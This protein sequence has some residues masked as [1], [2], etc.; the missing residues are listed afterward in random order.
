[1]SM[2]R[3]SIV[4]QIVITSIFLVFYA[5]FVNSMLP[6]KFLESEYIGSLIPAL[7]QGLYDHIRIFFI[8]SICCFAVIG[9]LFHHDGGS[10]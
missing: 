2:N 1:M 8:I 9:I 6:F 4:F 5:A 3:K 7:R 10:V